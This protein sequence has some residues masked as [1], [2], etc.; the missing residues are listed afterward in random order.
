MGNDFAFN[1]KTL[2]LGASTKE[3]RFSH[4][5]IKS[6][7]KHNVEVVA[8]GANTGMVGGVPI[9]TNKVEPGDIHTVT[10]YLNPKNQTDYIDY[11][12][13]LKPR[14]IIFN[15]GTENPELL[16]KARE[17]GIEITFNCTLVMLNNGSFFQ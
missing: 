2:V 13:A 3:N 11:I 7:T 16:T 1:H 8:I 6:L 10:L 12:I 4:L 14:R 17:N 9:L 15:P 5:A